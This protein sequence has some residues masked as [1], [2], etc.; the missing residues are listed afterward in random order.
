MR[1]IEVKTDEER[2]AACG[3]AFDEFDRAVSKQVK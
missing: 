3:V 1:C 2:L